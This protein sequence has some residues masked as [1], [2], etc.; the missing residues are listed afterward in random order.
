[1]LFSIQNEREWANLC[2]EVLRQPEVAT[3]PRFV[4]NSARVQHRDALDAIVTAA[5]AAVDRPE[6]IERLERARIA[7]GRVSSMADLAAHPQTGSSPS[8]LRP[9]RSLPC[10]GA[11]I[12]N[13]DP[14]FGAVPALGEHDAALRSEYASR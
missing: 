14:A 7:Y 13:Q 2:R 3:D 5:F 6:M 11:R 4:G 9:A 8:R 1:M 12:D 10:T